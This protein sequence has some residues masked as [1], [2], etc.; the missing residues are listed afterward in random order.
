MNNPNPNLI[1]CSTAVG[2]MKGDGLYLSKRLNTKTFSGLW[3][4][5][6]GKLEDNELPIYGAIREVEEE[7]GLKIDYSRLEYKVGIVGDPTTKVCYVYV[8]ELEQNE[9]P[10]KMEELATEWQWFTF[11]EALK[12]PLLPGIK[13]L[14]TQLK[15]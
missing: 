8:V 13:E 9:I 4:F 11:D 15:K 5:A 1:P 7:T 14:L 6:G 12:L 3:Q 2:L 10:K